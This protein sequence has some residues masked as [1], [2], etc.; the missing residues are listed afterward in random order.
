MHSG[1]QLLLCWNGLVARSFNTPSDE[2]CNSRVRAFTDFDY[3]DNVALLSELLS[4]LLSAPEMFVEEADPVGMTVNWKKKE[5]QSPGDLLP[6]VP[7]LKVSGEQVEAVT[8]FT[9][10][11]S[12]ITTSCGS[13]PKMYR[14]HGMA[15]ASMSDFD[16][17]WG[18]CVAFQTKVRL[19]DICVRSTALYA[20]EIGL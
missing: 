15:R 5:I 8:T 14:R 12:S 13:H 3:A 1:T 2:T 16:H 19:Y 7:D 17:I 18:F 6:P 4:L 10:L 9:S 20:S 11:G